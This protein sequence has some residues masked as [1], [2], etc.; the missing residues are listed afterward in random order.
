MSASTSSLNESNE[1]LPFA[2]RVNAF[3][4]AAVDEVGRRALHPHRPSLSELLLDPGLVLA[5]EEA[6]VEPLHVETEPSGDLLELPDAQVAIHLGRGAQLHQRV[7]VLPELALLGG[8]LRGERRVHRLLAVHDEVLEHEPELA[9][10]DQLLSDLALGAGVKRLADGALVLRE[11]GEHAPG[12][13]ANPGSCRWPAPARSADRSARRP[14]TARPWASRRPP[15][16][17]RRSPSRRTPRL[18]R[19][20]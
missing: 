9:G 5:R 7:V 3:S 20:R 8:G 16:R 15:A 18:S 14:G 4:R 1:R 6:R 11:L 10:L 2:V 12:R 19:R 17:R 13:Q